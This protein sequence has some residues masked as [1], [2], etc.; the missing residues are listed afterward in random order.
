MQI[1]ISNNT[2]TPIYEQI[3]TQIKSAIMSGE[4]KCGDS[5]P[6][7]SSSKRVTY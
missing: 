2:T 6:Y 7:E 1:L 5:L 4:L 3:I